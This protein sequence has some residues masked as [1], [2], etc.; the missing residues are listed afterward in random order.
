MIRS[1]Y[2]TTVKLVLSIAQADTLISETPELLLSLNRRNPYLDPLN[3]IQVH[4]LKKVRDEN[5]G[6]EKDIYLKPL[7]RSINAI[8]AGMRNTG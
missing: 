5:I 2:E 7:L 6:D 8:A 3:Q 4:L 1:E